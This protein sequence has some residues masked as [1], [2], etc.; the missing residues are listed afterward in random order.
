MLRKCEEYLARPG[1]TVAGNAVQVTK[2]FS[3][4]SADLY[5]VERTRNGRIIAMLISE[6]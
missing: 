2:H 1:E 6:S 3:L 4:I 5:H